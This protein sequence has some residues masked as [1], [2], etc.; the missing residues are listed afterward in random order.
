MKNI[1][2]KTGIYLIDFAVALW[3]GV[4][5][6]GIFITPIRLIFEPTPFQERITSSII[7]LIGTVAWLFVSAWKIAYEKRKFTLPHVVIPAIFTFAVQ[8]VVAYLCHFVQYTSGPAGYL[9]EAIYWGNRQFRWERWVEVPLYIY[10]G[11]MLAFDI[12][13]LAAMIAGEYFGAKKRQK[14]RAKLTANPPTDYIK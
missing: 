3:V 6:D 8:L 11:P 7:Q 14:D 10:F 12:L 2:S 4:L 13:Y 5:I 1:L 9:T